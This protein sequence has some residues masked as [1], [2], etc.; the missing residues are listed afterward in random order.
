MLSSVCIAILKPS[1]S[2]PSLFAA[3]TFTSWKAS[4]EVSVARW[5]ILSRCFSIV[6]P[7][8][9]LGTTKAVR[10]RCPAEGSVEAKTVNQSAWPALVM[11]IFEPLRT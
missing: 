6:T 2:S 1:P 7:S 3:G 10:P 8:A 11:N 4:A 5:P 9:S